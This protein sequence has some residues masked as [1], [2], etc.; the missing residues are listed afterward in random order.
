[1][2]IIISTVQRPNKTPYLDRLIASIRQDYQGVIHLIVGGK[3]VSYVA[4]YND[5][6]V[7][8]FIGDKEEQFEDNI[9]RAAYGYYRCLTYD[10]TVPAL[11]FE[12]DGMLD[13]DW[14]KKLQDLI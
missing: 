1:M 8:H 11:I 2:N 13:K 9:K 5:G 4:Q 10:W 6:F 7:K 14:Y 12:D 3:D